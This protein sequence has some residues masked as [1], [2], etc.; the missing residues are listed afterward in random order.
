MTM[1]FKSL[2]IEDHTMAWPVRRQGQTVLH[3]Q[4]FFDKA[5]K[6]KP[7]DLQVIRISHCCQQMGVYIVDTVRGDVKP[8][9]L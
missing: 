4:G 1:G 5:F 7:M 3:L 6:A 2:K 9:R 8:A